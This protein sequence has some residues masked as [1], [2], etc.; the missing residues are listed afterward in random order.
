MSHSFNWSELLRRWSTARGPPF[1]RMKQKIPSSS[2]NFAS[3]V[4]FCCL[5]F[6]F[7]LFNEWPYDTGR[8]R[9]A[10]SS[11][12]G[13]TFAAYAVQ[14]Q[15]WVDYECLGENCPSSLPE[16]LAEWQGIRY[17]VALTVSWLYFMCYLSSV[18]FLV[19]LLVAAISS[20]LLFA[21]VIHTCFYSS[22]Y[23]WR[24]NK[25]N[26]DDIP[27]VLCTLDHVVSERT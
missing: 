3:D 21:L 12:G 15:H 18:N 16:D 5:D 14:G 8:F 22:I 4:V 13:V 1:V 7:T 6:F 10:L 20:F 17:L 26:G 2:F 24:V 11:Y 23:R 25:C 27:C 9:I 19:M